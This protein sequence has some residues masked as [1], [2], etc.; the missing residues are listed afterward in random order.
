MKGTLLRYVRNQISFFYSFSLLLLSAITATA[1]VTGTRTIGVEYPTLASAITDL[2][3][4]GIAG[5]VT[6]NVPAGHTEVAPAGG[7]VLGSAVLNASISATATLTIQKSGTGANPL[8]TAPV[9]TSTSA[10]GIFIIAGTDRVTISGI[11]L[12]ESAANTTATTRMEWG[13][14]LVKRQNTA[15]FDGCQFVTIQGCTITLNRLNTPTVGI[16]AGNHIAT[17][18][19]ALSITATSDAMNDCA[20]YSNTIQ[21][22]VTGISLRG[23]AGA[24]SPYSLYDQNNKVGGT[25]AISGNTIQNYAGATSGSGINLQYQ[26]NPA[27]AYNNIN[28][29]AGGGM[30]STVTLYGVYVQN[31][32]N[33]SA[34]IT[35]NTILLTQ[36]STGSASYDVHVNCSGTGTIN[37][38]NNV[39]SAAG[40]SSGS[41]YMIYFGGANTY[42]S[43]DQNTFYNIN[44][45]TT[46]TL[47]FVYHNTA[48]SP[49][50]ITCNNNRTGGPAV[51]YVNKTGAGGSVY[52]YYNNSGST[53]GYAILN[54][55]DLSN[56]IMAGSPTFYGLSETNGG[57]GQYKLMNN[58]TISNISAA[59]GSLYALRMGWA[60]SAS[61]TNN[62]VTNIDAGSG[63]A[64]G[65]YVVSGTT[66]T[67]QANRVRNLISAGG[68]V[69]GIYVN[70]GTTVNVVGDTINALSTSATTGQANGIYQAG[71]TTVNI[72]HNKMY[73]IEAI[74]TGGIARGIYLG[75]N[76]TMVYNN[77]IGDIRTP[78]YTGAGG[79]QL[80]GIYIN[81]GTAHDIYYNTVYLSGGST[82]ADFGSSGI[83]S[84]TS[85]TVT[86]RN[87]IFANL[88][89]PA[90]TGQTVA[91]RRGSTTLTSYGSASN[92]N[93]FYAG[94]PGPANVIFHDGTAAYETIGDFK[95]LVAPR[96]VN[97]VSENPPFISTTGASATFLHISPS[98]PTQ[99]EGGAANITGITTDWDG[100]IRAGNPGYAGSG[101]AP[102]IG[103]DEGAYMPTDLSAPAIVYTDLTNTCATGDRTLTATITDASGIP[104]TGTLVPR[105]YFR[106]NA[107][108]WSSAAGVL[109]SG[110]AT[111]SNWSFTISTAAMGGLTIADTV[112]Y[113]VIA[114]DIAPAVN[115]GSNPFSGLVATNVNTI[116]TY[117]AAP[118]SYMILPTLSG[119]Y[120]VGVG[121]VYATITDAVAAYNSSCISGAVTF[122]LMD[123]TYPSETFPI[124][125]HHNISASAANTLT[126]RPAT[127]VSPTVTGAAT[128]IFLLN[129]ADHVTIDGSN[130]PV[131]NSVCPPVASS[132]N[133]TIANTSTSTSSAVVW[134]QTSADGDSATNNII[135][136]CNITGN[137]PNQT[138]AGIGSG[139]ATISN[140]STG[141]GNHNNHYEN[142]NIS[143]VQIGIYSQGRS[144]ALKNNGTIINQ[145]VMT[146]PSPNGIGRYGILTG[147]ENNITV[148]GNSIGK[149]LYTGT[150]DVS[151]ISMGITFASLGNSVTTGNEVTNATITYNT[152][153]SFIA[154]NAWSDAG[155]AVAGAASGTTTIANNMISRVLGHGT[156]GDITAGIFVGGVAGS[157]VNVYYNT[158]SLSGTLTG[159]TYP[160]FAICITGSDPAVN[161]RDNIFVNT[162]SNGS[163]FSPYAIGIAGSA[164]TNLASNNNNFFSSGSALAATGSLSGTGALATLAD[165]QTTTG[166]DAASKNILPAFISAGDMHLQ[167]IV[168]NA[169]LHNTG[170]VLPVTTD[171]D[172]ESRSATPDIGADEFVIPLCSGAVAGT[173]TP[174]TATFCGVGTTTITATGYSTTLGIAYQWLSSADGTSWT[175]IAGAT[176]TT[177]VIS[178]AITDTT[179]Y[180][181]RAT[182]TVSGVSDSAS[183]TVIVNPLPAITVTPD[184]GGYCSGTYSSVTMTASGATSY[185]WAPGTGLSGVTGATVVASPA[186]TTAYTVTGTD[187]AGCTNTH[188]STVTVT[189]TPP[190]VVV[191]PAADTICAGTGVALTGSS[192]LPDTAFLENFNS[193]IGAWVV[194]NTGT[195]SPA[196]TQWTSRADGY[197]YG[198]TTF[199]SPDATAFVMTNS[200]AGGSGMTTRTSLTSPAF[201]LA[202]YTSATLNFRH[203]YRYI[204]SDVFARVEISTDGGATWAT[205]RDYRTAAATVGGAASFG[206][207]TLDV[208]PYAG[209][210]NCKI[211][212]NYSA[213]Y[214]WYWA[215]DAVS[216]T[217]TGSYTNIT[218]SPMTGLYTDASLEAI[219]TGGPA[220]TVYASPAPGVT[221]YTATATNGACTNTGTTTI[222]VLPQPVPFVVTGGGSYCTG[223]TGV[224]IGL[225][226]SAMGVNYQLYNGAT[227]VGSPVPG[228]GAALSFGLQ[229]AAGTYSVLATNMSTSC[230]SGMTGSASIIVAPLPVAYDVTGSGSFCADDSGLHVG[231]SGSDTGVL[232]QLYNGATAIGGPI[233][234]TG[235]ALDLGV[236][237]AAGT[238]TVRATSAGTSCTNTMSGTAT[239]VVDPLPAAYTMTVT[240]G[241][242][243]C[244]GDTGVHIGLSGSQVGVS[245]QLYL[246]SSP[247]GGAVMGTGAPLDLG[248]VS[249][250]GTY[251]VYATNTATSC[252][253]AMTGSIPVFIN[254]LPS[255]YA[256]TGG[257]SLCAG[258]TGVH[259]GLSGSETAITYQLMLG[260]VPVGSPVA[261][262][263][264]FIDFGAVTVG[265]TYSVIATTGASCSTTM[266]GSATV[267]VN[268]APVVYTLTGGGAYCVG[269]SGASIGLSNSEVGVSYQL[270]NGGTPV[271][272]PVTGTGAPLG[273]GTHSAPGTYSISATNVSTGC[274]SAMSGT[275]SVFAAPLPATFA[276]TGGGAYCMGGSGVVVGLAGSETGVNYQL[277]IGT[278]AMGGP[279]AGTGGAIPFGLQTVAGTYT[280]VAT[281][282]STGCTSAMTGS[283]TVSEIPP[284]T[285]YIVTGGGAY[286]AGG[287]G[288]DVGLNS[289]DPGVSYQLYHGGTAIGGPVMGTGA[290]LSFGLQTL[291]GT[292]TVLAISGTTS[293]TAVMM[294]TATVFINPTVP[295]TVSITTGATGPVCVGTTVTFTAV[296]V[297]GG[298]SPAYQWYVN[299]I[300][301]GTGIAYS[302]VP[303]NGDIV[304]VVI[305]SSSCAVPDTGSAA[306][307]MSVTSGL[308]P[309]VSI[310]ASPGLTVCEGSNVTLSAV[311]VNGGAAPAYLWTKN[312]INVA[313]GPTYTYVPDS[314]DVV[315]VTLYSSHPCRTADSVVS[316]DATI[317]VVPLV[318]PSVTLT[319]SPG[320][321]ISPGQTVTLTA[322]A[323]GAGPAPVYQWSL[324]SVPM[325]GATTNTLVRS[326]FVNGDLVTV[327][328]TSS[329]SCAGLIAARSVT[330]TVG[331]GVNN[332]V[333][334]KMDLRL[335]PNPNRGTFSIR[336]T[337]N[338]GLSNEATVE[339][340]DILGQV[341]YKGSADIRD[342]QVDKQIVLDNSLANG[343][344]LLRFALGGETTTFHF[345]LER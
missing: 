97:S 188:V 186:S 61:F 285:T 283:A 102:D 275:T 163:S 232:Y 214:G 50:Y 339:V 4:M 101:T 66:D 25:T 65:L 237:T 185:T 17:S 307:T 315:R 64:Y 211:R 322:T 319:A 89:T 67:L 159:A 139:S 226:G 325:P 258:D 131:T 290:P 122:Q 127:G 210:A 189:A 161:I 341:V 164:F 249:A 205:V 313:T 228:T 49:E 34:G 133:L 180:R 5:A 241:G 109:T 58:N 12:T 85:P 41:M 287:A 267:V 289:S 29:I 90:G 119:T 174:A 281:N 11:D 262:T 247:S 158:V 239:I 266:T 170:A 30:A 250:V 81:G 330:I 253:A 22:T 95:T 116:T 62:T 243:Y 52:G 316:S 336:G 172:C 69:Y 104:T 19:T 87:N 63:S 77:Y 178:P 278:T 326:S 335:M 317:A 190:A 182:C 270:Y 84:S 48:T 320:T 143:R 51:P 225:S 245:Y 318:S 121:M 231:L 2:N 203:Y 76:T 257:G 70:G 56:I 157:V 196:L 166:E 238:Y 306:I 42:V 47:A 344:Y 200:D 295:P 199:H 35:N 195:S 33:V 269:S 304:R 333:S 215:V 256:V 100:N 308:T 78:A 37:V 92:N 334:G 296:P 280:A 298:Y 329:G 118:N 255:A 106:K 300:A 134:L 39:L 342:G 222:T 233:A 152:I 248:L 176:G 115:I 220:T 32:T 105:I 212:F 168:A 147:Y 165:W 59:G 82:G 9:G 88:C 299:G 136:N 24:A 277:Y 291:A 218:W 201:S 274:S 242:S 98:M 276:V 79:T 8:L 219:Y 96:D 10:D 292:Y 340:V 18:T 110:T 153:D 294:G 156:G 80:S 117:P 129:G 302:Y 162:S 40:G 309:S 148:S 328:V 264:T 7:Y 221:I 324:N 54:D 301:A 343:M 141:T 27:V 327:R 288:V 246:G 3:T 311:P 155:I 16:Y 167:P 151:A 305:T 169:P 227:A 279:V 71:G 83:Y 179:Y 107:G 145:N 208:T 204:A 261:G 175:T 268:A 198:T 207:A 72:G 13:Y 138:L 20:F 181:F 135:R 265:G 103:A 271:G 114:Q 113:F 230:T 273:L 124:T 128:A 53:S 312:G 297:N 130:A 194:E 259:I 191:T 6:I 206:T 183:T 260:G 202:G 197:M 235:A 240:G 310:A 149:V 144:A 68:N 209:A 272:S 142:N 184:G 213:G 111:G 173:V 36:G 293:C 332:T 132:R 43:T 28:N 236:Q 26:N 192:M 99:I 14:A 284:P 345:T 338:N 137:A 108:P 244:A 187:A 15:P 234:G 150:G 286:C 193:G 46:G 73:D 38:N 323:A 263:G 126:I 23:Y 112:K 251:S 331:V 60:A 45:G 146:T 123:A 44:V 91:Y 177:Y 21:N 254:P 337:A 57:S 314:G 216:V 74:G 154:D 217:G 303:A 224:A 282:A 94:V 75:T 1:Q 160:S 86:L 140:S 223:G 321:T 252:S 93:L 125:I 120:N 229:T 55:N 171:H 31:G